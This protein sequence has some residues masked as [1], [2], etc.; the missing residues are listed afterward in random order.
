MSVI[1]GKFGASLENIKRTQCS[2]GFKSDSCLKCLKEPKFRV[3]MMIILN[4]EYIV[5][6]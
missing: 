4:N 3:D 2:M 5:K 6:L 1:E